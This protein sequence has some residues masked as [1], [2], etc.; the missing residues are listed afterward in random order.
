MS[1][2]FTYTTE[3]K[4]N[5][6]N[7]LVIK[8]ISDYLIIF[9]KIQRIAFHRIK[10]SY[11]KYGKLDSKVKNKLIA[12]LKDEFNLTS[13]AIDSIVYNMVG[14][15]ESIKELKSYELNQLY[16]RK[17]KFEKDLVKLLDEKTL[18]KT[19]KINQ[20]Y[21]SNE[22]ITSYKNLKIKIYW[23]RNR[24]NKI[25]QRIANLENE[26]ET[27][28]FKVCFGTKNNLHKDYQVFVNQR[29]SELYFI[30]RAGD[31]ACNNNFQLE[32][33]KKNN[34][35]YFKVR[36]EIDLE[37][38]KYEYGK[39]YF[40]KKQK[41]KIKHLLS[42]KVSPLTYR[43]K[44]KNGKI[45]LQLM[46]QEEEVKS[47]DCLTRNTYGTIGVDF[48]KGFVA[49]TETDSNGNMINTFNLNYRFG[50]GNK[51]KTDLINISN[52][53]TNLCLEKGKDLVVE[54]L[55][56]RKKKA[57]LISKKSPKYN[58]MLSN[59]AYSTYGKIIKS[60]CHKKKVYLREVTPAW[61][62]YIG[63]NK[64]A[65]NMKL[66]IHTSASF[67]IA[68]KGM[69]L[70]DSLSK[71]RVKKQKPKYKKYEKRI[72]YRGKKKTTSILELLFNK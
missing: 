30:G 19:T 29:D 16:K 12:E 70:V 52:S 55:D 8:Y 1:N 4:Q 15:F 10:N 67:V 11:I 17:N 42:S 69:F 32:Y 31:T 50:Q 54:R 33:N 3:I 48:N 2:V 58:E 39:V 21:V 34:Q 27:S 43:I 7:Q 23:K 36:K 9:N 47:S 44:I 65:N 13:R 24:L 18:M 5:N 14:R 38:G 20:K 35:F 28:K 41:H 26:I 45:L 64:Y 63:K 56:F 71:K 72:P 22:D 60:A 59:L 37:D 40:N 46:F 53:L 61:T 66:N 51:T 49:V 6:D 57:E 68:R 25:N 62:S